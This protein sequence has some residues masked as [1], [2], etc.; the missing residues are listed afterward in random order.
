MEITL[1]SPCVPSGPHH[2]KFPFYGIADLDAFIR[3]LYHIILLVWGSGYFISQSLS[4]V[5]SCTLISCQSF[6]LFI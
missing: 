3:F 6:V 4:L 1:Y 5:S 2:A